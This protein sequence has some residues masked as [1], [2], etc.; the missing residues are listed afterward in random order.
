MKKLITSVLALLCLTVAFAAKPASNPNPLYA[1]QIMIPV[2]K[3]GVKI[4]LLE[5]SGISKTD[6]EKMTGKK[7]S[8][9]Q[10]FAFKS[11]QRKMNKGINS[12]GVITSKRMKKMF[13]AGE[14]GFHVGGFALGFLV[15]LIG[16]LIAYLINDDYKKNRV[17][18]AWI[19]LGVGIILGVL[20]FLAIY[21]GSVI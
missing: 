12:E 14:T 19:G 16:V 13:Y 2:G 21:S 18:W 1:S 15:G 20:F 11:A 8:G 4:S 7:M 17:K 10:A 3:T 5:L 6:L 9:A